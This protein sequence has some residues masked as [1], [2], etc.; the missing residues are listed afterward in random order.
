MTQKTAGHTFPEGFI[1]GT[2]SSSYQIEGAVNEGGRGS[3]IWDDFCRVP[4]AIHDGTSG[5]VACDHVH[6]YKEDISLLKE[7]GT[8]AYRFSISWPRIIPDGNGSSSQEGIAFYRDLLLELKRN[9]IKASVTLYHWDLPSALENLGGWRRR[10]TAIDF[11]RYA[12][13]CFEAFDDLVDSWITLNEPF[14][15]SVLGHLTG[16]HA[17][18]M[19][20]RGA[21]HKVIHHLN[22]AHGL[23]MEAYRSKG[24]THPIGTTLNLGTPLAASDDPKDLLAA[25]RAADFVSRLYLSPVIGK[26]YPQRYL[27][28]YPQLPFPIE[29]GD[30]EIIGRHRLDFLGIN[31]YTEET[32]VFDAGSAEQY[33]SVPADHPKTGMQWDIVPEGLLRLLRWTCDETEGIPMIITENG[34]AWDDVLTLD[35]DGQEQVIDTDRVRYLVDHLGICLDAVEEGLPL[36]G[37]YAWSNMDNFEWA[38]GLSK[39]FGIIYCDFETL[40]RTP[41]ASYYR[42]Q[43]IIKKRSLS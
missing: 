29:D 14:C 37:Y 41:K 21:M 27:D 16:E 20:D 19:Q 34:S 17:P 38:H 26:G 11:A 1:F 36:I 39:R 35:A 32:V 3:S 12:A 8:D 15:T 33:R 42:Y 18:G 23:A 9:S 31:Y 5:D 4:G 28:A 30:I 13:I 22:L 2:A 43:E 7:L 25:D 10:E 6:R 40:K 24:Y